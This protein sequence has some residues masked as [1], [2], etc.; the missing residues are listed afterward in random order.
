MAQVIL[1]FLLGLGIFL[2]GFFQVRKSRA[3]R[4]WPSANGTITASKIDVDQAAASDEESTA[5]LFIA[6]EYQY[7]VHGQTHIGKRIRF[8]QKRYGSKKQAQTALSK[9]PVGGPVQVFYD[10][11]H[12]DHCILE[13]GNTTGWVFAAVGAIMIML[14][15]ASIFK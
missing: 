14:A 12:P 7:E 6:L 1:V 11:Q 8:D 2:V 4:S 5:T 13:Q 9:Y 15:M 10:P 3:S